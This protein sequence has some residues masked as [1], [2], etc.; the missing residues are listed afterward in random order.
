[1]REK[2]DRR[3]LGGQEAAPSTPAFRVE[4]ALT[5]QMLHV[6]PCLEFTPFEELSYND[7]RVGDTQY[8]KGF[9]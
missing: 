9:S 4:D 3:Q 6:G 8:D 5:N 2:T 7:I 1:M